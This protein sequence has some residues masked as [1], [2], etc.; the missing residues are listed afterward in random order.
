MFSKY[1][2]FLPSAGQIVYM[3]DGISYFKTLA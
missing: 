2:A 3:Y 1:M